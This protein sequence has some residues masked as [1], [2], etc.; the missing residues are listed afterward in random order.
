VKNL[1]TQTAKATDDIS[2]QI[3]GMQTAT[4]SAVDAI[5]GIGGIIRDMNDIATI[6]AAAVGE[7]SA[8]TGEISRNVIQ[9]AAGTREV[10]STIGQLTEASGQTGA[11][12]G[13]VRSA[14]GELAHQS[15]MLRT[16][17]ERFLADI[18]TA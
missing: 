6:I 14:A 1:A 16:E 11:A 2:A 4:G 13:Q 18:Q 9:A 10:S 5:Q 12:A 17:V 15:E 7:Q 3:A 8:A